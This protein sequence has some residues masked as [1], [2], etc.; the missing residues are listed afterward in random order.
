MM[1]GIPSGRLGL[2]GFRV[3]F[4]FTLNLISWIGVNFA[5]R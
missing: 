5:W 1:D 2:M 4:P 3:L